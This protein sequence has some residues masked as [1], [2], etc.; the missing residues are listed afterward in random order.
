MLHCHIITSPD[1][2]KEV[3]APFMD[4][5]SSWVVN[6]LESKF[7]LQGLLR[8]QTGP[9]LNTDR[10]LRASEL[11]QKI[12]VSIDP[13]WTALSS[14][15]AEFLI[16]KWMEEILQTGEWRLSSKDFGRAYST[17][18]QI[19]PLL[20][21]FQGED[22]IEEWFAEKQEAKERWEDWY[23]LGRELWGRFFESKRIP[24][25]WMKG[26][27]INEELPLI[28]EAPLIVDLGLDIDDVESELLLNLSRQHDIHVIVPGT[29]TEN[30]VYLPLLNRSEAQTYE[31]QG[32]VDTP[33]V[34]KK[35]PSMLAEVKEAVGQVR[36]WLDQGV[37]LQQIGIVSPKIENYW[38][39]LFEHLKVEGIPVNKSLATPS[40]QMPVFQDWMARLRLMGQKIQSGDGEKVFFPWDEDPLL[41]YRDFRSQLTNVYD[42]ED[43]SRVKAVETS[44]PPGQE[45]KQ[46]LSFQSFLA[47]AM[48]SLPKK[49]WAS[50]EPLWQEMDDLFEMQEELSIEKWISFFDRYLTRSEIKVSDGDREGLFVLPL[51]AALNP[52]LDCVVVMGLSEADI[53]EVETTALTWGDVESIKINFGFNLPH[54]D[55]HLALDYLKWFR[56]KQITHQVYTHGETHFSGSF[57]S[58]SL[59]WLQGCLETEGSLDLQA[60][61]R[62]RWDAVRENDP[63]Q[64]LAWDAERVQRCQQGIEWDAGVKS[65]DQVPYKNLSLSASSLEEFFQCPFKLFAR[66]ALR[67]AEDPLLDLDID[68]MTRGQL[69]HRICELVVGESLYYETMDKIDGLVERARKDVAVTTLTDT[70]WGFLKPFYLEATK[71][72][73]DSEREWRRQYPHTQTLAVEKSLRTYLN[74]SAE[75][76]VFHPTE[77]IPFRGI[78][79]RVDHNGQDQVAIVDYKSSD[80]GLTQY[81]SWIKNGKVQLALYSLA[82]VEGVLDGKSHDVVGA[83]YFALKTLD[84]SKGFALSES[85]SQFLPSK[86]M[87]R[88]DLDNLMDETKLL[89][90]KIIEEIQEGQIQPLPKDEDERICQRCDWRSLCRYPALNQ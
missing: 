32:A 36:Q 12:L 11:W 58:P 17:I 38:P 86:K 28:T 18:R 77:G 89:V 35:L 70:I 30:E 63:N 14:H 25:E 10:V 23:R 49:Y 22:A 54:A 74:L 51:K 39:T 40:S 59:F 72:F 90:K 24:Q 50:M 13:Q 76:K 19:L 2:K 81:K 88:E 47:L 48:E 60:P 43:Y 6:D 21:H 53:T 65:R 3:Y 16:E 62:T 82:L 26:I 44:L 41:P 37:P 8:E 57:Q 7:W 9:V 1:Q 33:P 64:D 5:H 73:I 85:D 34:F 52:P 27:L 69:L 80:S 46:E 29:E 84:R 42:I 78:I 66:K 61:R 55:R 56:T 83:F 20:S 71:A 75:D 87:S 68:P 45:L 79:D 15:F 4:R 67:L 31:E